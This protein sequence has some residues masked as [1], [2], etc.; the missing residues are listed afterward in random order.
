MVDWSLL[1][2]TVPAGSERTADAVPLSIAPRAIRGRLS[3]WAVSEECADSKRFGSTPGTCRSRCSILSGLRKDAGRSL[4]TVPVCSAVLFV[5]TAAAIT[6]CCPS[7]C[8]ASCAAWTTGRGFL[9]DRSSLWEGRS[10]TFASPIPAGPVPER[11]ARTSFVDSIRDM[12]LL[13]CR[14]VEEASA[15]PVRSVLCVMAWVFLLGRSP[16]SEAPGSFTFRLVPA[17]PVSVWTVCAFWESLA[18]AVTCFARSF[19]RTEDWV[20]LPGSF[21]ADAGRVVCLVGF[22]LAAPSFEASAAGLPGAERA[23]AFPSCC[24]DWVPVP[25]N[26]ERTA[27]ALFPAGA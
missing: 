13:S 1:L 17:R 3:C 16:V 6:L 15:P 4:P 14:A 2:V 23:A 26:D 8:V 12:A 18:V 27:P 20:F 10:L 9:P 21:S 7:R 24:T 19:C 22:D 25:A 5:S 11:E